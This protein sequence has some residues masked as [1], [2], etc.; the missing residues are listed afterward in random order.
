MIQYK[1]PD[2]GGL[3][4]VSCI[5]MIPPI[6]VYRCQSCPYRHEIKGKLITITAP[7]LPKGDQN[8]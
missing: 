2:C 6:T 8:G 4:V 3:V 7:S 5:T 1:C